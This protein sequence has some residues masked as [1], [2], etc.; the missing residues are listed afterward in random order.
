MIIAG[1]PQ[2]EEPPACPT[3]DPPLGEGKGRARQ[4]FLACTPGIET[5]YDPTCLRAMAIRA[6]DE[7]PTPPLLSP[8]PPSEAWSSS[9]CHDCL[10]HVFSSDLFLSLLFTRLPCLCP[11]LVDV[12]FVPVPCTANPRTVPRTRSTENPESDK[13]GNI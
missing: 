11:P 2:A 10:L 6:P 4:P 8:P 1:A 5:G 3:G 9:F 12:L 7:N 13:L